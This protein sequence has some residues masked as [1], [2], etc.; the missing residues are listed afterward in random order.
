MD[1]IPWTTISDFWFC[2]KRPDGT[3]CG[4]ARTCASNICIND[5]CT[6]DRLVNGEA[7]LSDNDCATGA[8]GVS[9]FLDILD[10]AETICCDSGES[11]LLDGFYFCGNFLAGAACGSDLMCAS[12]SCLSRGEC[13]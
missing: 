11:V 10:T 7:C 12:N 8:C 6:S 4:D 9:E 3:A 1:D 2:G 13:A 5:A